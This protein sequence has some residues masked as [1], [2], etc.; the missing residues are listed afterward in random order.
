MVRVGYCLALLLPALVAAAPSA[1]TRKNLVRHVRAT[2]TV[3]P[4]EAV[5]IQVPA[6]VD[7]DTGRLVLTK[8]V[9]SGT[10]VKAGDIVA[11]FDRTRLLDRARDAKARFE[12]LTHQVDQ[13]KA[14]HRSDQ[15]KRASDVQQ[16]EADLEKAR[17]EL[18]KG[19]LLSDIDRLKAE[20]RLEAAQAHVASLKKIDALRR[21]AEAAELA[22]LELQRDRQKLTMDRA[23]RNAE[24]L[25]IHAPIAGMVVLGMVWKQSSMG[26]PQEG[27]QL[28]SGQAI[29]RVFSSS[30]MELLVSV[31]EPDGA[32]LK[33]GARAEVRLDAY[34]NLVFHAVFISAAPVATNA[35]DTS[36]K[37]FQ[38]RFRLEESDPHLLPDLSAAVDL[39]VA[40][41]KPVLTVPRSAVR[42]RAGV[43]YV[44]RPDRREQPVSL[45]AFDDTDVEITEGLAE[46]DPVVLP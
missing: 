30:E 23:V 14:Q 32:L 5:S 13:K 17:L 12:D 40:T 38:A 15:T 4:V 28:W 18:R 22:V 24:L 9:R 45:G 7:S 34:P 39:E 11:E 42:F 6:I 43:P 41:E 36:L 2:A 27:D 1:A 35:P 31:G 46:H 25:E 37:T 33:P 3:Q 20:T 8:I 29:M 19:L 16:A 10:A 21:R 44:V 26:Q